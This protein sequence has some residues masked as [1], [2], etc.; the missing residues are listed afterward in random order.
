MYLPLALLLFFTGNPIKAQ[1]DSV[2]RNFLDDRGVTHTFTGSPKIGVRA[3]IGGRSLYHMGLPEEQLAA[4]WGLW[5][6]RGSDFDPENP[7]AGSIYGDQDPGIDETNFLSTARNLSPSCWK[8]PRGCF[9]WDSLDDLVEMHQNG[10]LDYIILIDNASSGHTCGPNVT[11]SFCDGGGVIDAEAEGIPVVFVDTLYDYDPACRLENYTV[12]DKNLCI[13]RSTIDIAQKVEELAKALVPNL[14]TTE[15]DRQRDE[16]CASAESFTQ[17]MEEVHQKGIRVKVSIAGT[18]TNFLTGETSVTVRDFD[19]LQLW[20]PRTFE[21]LGMPLLHSN[22]SG[23]V[24]PDTYFTDCPNGALSETCNDNT[25]Y[26]VDYWLF[27]SRSFALINDPDTIEQ[28]FPDKA[29]LKGQLWH[30]S[31]NDGPVSYVTIKTVLDE[32]AEKLASAERVHDETDC[33]P[34]DPTGPE[35]L[36]AGL[37]SNQYVCYNFDLIQSEYLCDDNDN[38]SGGGFEICFSGEN[39]VLTL[40]KGTIQMKNLKLGDMVHVGKGEYSRVYSFGHRSDDFTAEYLQL[41][42]GSRV[43]PLEISKD[44]M[45]FSESLGPVPASSLSVDDRIIA[46]HNKKTTVE[47][48]KITKVNRVGAYAPFTESGTIVV[49][50]LLASNYVSLQEGASG[51]FIVAG[52]NTISMHWLAHA[53]QAPHRLFCRLGAN[54]CSRQAYTKEGI[55][56]WVSLPLSV[57][58]WFLR[59]HIL[60]VTILSI[61]V[62]FLAVLFHLIEALFNLPTYTGSIFCAVIVISYLLKT[63]A[64]RNVPIKGKC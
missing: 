22:S 60:V 48:T 29:L 40:D 13:G 6:I 46:G 49:N 2:Q 25:L 45:V 16:A 9:R 64:Y 38:D 10:E 42:V 21:E 8:N 34:A 62:I 18:T 20:F 44:H 32:M 5:A 14:D 53:F 51:S 26:P 57:S 30:Y 28:V 55:S 11:F 56:Y 4:I 19:P 59:Q 15:I 12:I 54:V 3:G 58:K 1:D 35:F 47:I 17:T 52:T 24:L 39:D 27:D 41:H 31:R 37:D 63:E 61:P 33:T 7:E 23:N 50:G 43:K 36:L